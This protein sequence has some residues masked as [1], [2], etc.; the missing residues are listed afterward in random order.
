[1]KCPHCH[2]ENEKNATFCCNCN[3]WILGSVFEEDVAEP[4]MQTTEPVKAKPKKRLSWAVAAV[5]T[6]VLVVAVV[7]LWPKNADPSPTQP[8]LE[9]TP[10]ATDEPKNTPPPMTISPP[11]G[12]IPLAQY[13]QS[14]HYLS[15][16][17]DLETMV[18]IFDD[19]V[20]ETD[21]PLREDWENRFLVSITGDCAVYLDGDQNLYYISAIGCELICEEVLD[22][23]LNADGGTV[24]YL[25]MGGHLKLYRRTLDSRIDLT[26]HYGGVSSFAISPDGESYAY[27]TE[28]RK[29]FT[30]TAQSIQAPGML[31]SL[32]SISNGGG[33]IYAL[34]E[35][36]L[37]LALESNG[38]YG[39]YHT[40]NKDMPIYLSA[41]H[42][43]ILYRSGNQNFLCIGQ[44]W[45]VMPDSDMQ[46]QPVKPEGT[47]YF[48]MGALITFPCDD[49]R[50]QVYCA[51]ITYDSDTEIDYPIG[52]LYY[53]DPN[54][55]EIRLIESEAYAFRLDP[56]GQYL[57]YINGYAH[58]MQYDLF[59]DSSQNLAQAGAVDFDLSPDG[60][61]IYYNTS[62]E[63]KAQSIATGHVLHTFTTKNP[64][65]L[66][67]TKDNAFFSCHS[68]TSG[69]V[70]YGYQ[71]QSNNNPLLT[72][73]NI[74]DYWISD[75]GVLYIRYAD[76]ILLVTA[77]G[78][79][80]IYWIYFEDIPVLE[81]DVVIP[82]E[83]VER[84]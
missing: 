14:Q 65:A 32:L 20:I 73:S 45:Y 40:I 39:V 18:F 56:S 12:F 57:Y 30:G 62:T 38:T 67:I 61:Y 3:A 60:K 47:S 84:P 49:L 24:I 7:L 2:T 81:P 72:Y 52:Q 21:I 63:L 53:V 35:G 79:Q 46:L 76:V 69:S 26:L 71:P 34:M 55:N 25:T 27:V 78:A 13:T 23:R 31:T 58:L 59:N 33:T 74:Q 9:A 70:L 80:T 77:D 8:Q 43:Q 36:D 37:L 10:A 41:D 16:I 54:L 64:Q 82:D 29:I 51:H 11:G 28:G 83:E 17:E 68:L 44:I 22:V 48:E 19:K 1:M 5:V 50:G 66:F 42:S 4:V 6:A 15:P 75:A